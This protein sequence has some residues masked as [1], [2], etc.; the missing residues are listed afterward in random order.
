[1]YIVFCSPLFFKHLGD[2]VAIFA[3]RKGLQVSIATVTMIGKNVRIL[4]DLN[5]IIVPIIIR[6]VLKIGIFG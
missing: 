4:I 2:G 5:K 6:V 3:Y 1:M